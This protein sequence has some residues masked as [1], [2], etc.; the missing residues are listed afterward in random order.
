M[1]IPGE[2]GSWVGMLRLCGQDTEQAAEGGVYPL[3]GISPGF[4]LTGQIHFPDIS[5]ETSTSEVSPVG[6]GACKS[7]HLNRVHLN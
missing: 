6:G 1:H 7:L 4:S 3:Q 5:G 2:L